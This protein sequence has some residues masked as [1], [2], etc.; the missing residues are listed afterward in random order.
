MCFCMI[1][2]FWWTETESSCSC[3]VQLF[4]QCLLSGCCTQPRGC[5]WCHKCSSCKGAK[6]KSVRIK[7][8][9]WKASEMC[10]FS[11]EAFKGEKCLYMFFWVKFRPHATFSGFFQ[12]KHRFSGDVRTEALGNFLSVDKSLRDQQGSFIRLALTHRG[13]ISPV[14]D[15]GMITKAC[16]A[17]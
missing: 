13:V 16:A 3:S 6:P 1:A 8:S 10:V 17:W 14:W 9:T 15:S 12:M 2:S 7:M 5:V 4:Y 11:C